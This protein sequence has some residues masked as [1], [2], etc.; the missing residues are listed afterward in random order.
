MSVGSMNTDSVL[1]ST[2]SWHCAVSEICS[3][4]HGVNELKMCNKWKDVYQF[5]VYNR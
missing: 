3:K 5:H 4:K 2:V 1:F